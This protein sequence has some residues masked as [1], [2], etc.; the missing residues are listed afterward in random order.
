MPLRLSCAPM[1]PSG[2]LCGLPAS[3]DQATR[4][5]D[6]LPAAHDRRDLS[7]SPAAWPT[8]F[9][10]V[11][12]RPTFGE[13]APIGRP[14][15]RVSGCRGRVTRHDASGAADRRPS[16]ASPPQCVAV[17]PG[18]PIWLSAALTKALSSPAPP[19]LQTFPPA[20]GCTCQES[21]AVPRSPPRST[22][23]P[24]RF[25]ERRSGQPAPQ[26]GK[27]QRRTCSTRA[28]GNGSDG[29]PSPACSDA[30]PIASGCSRPARRTPSPIWCSLRHRYP[31]RLTD[32]DGSQRAS[33]DHGSRCLER[34]H[35]ETRAHPQPLME[36]T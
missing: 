3:A 14:W 30:L 31:E 6:W 4:R 10:G 12:G 29:C 33:N 26:N 20:S 8:A 1:L 15:S 16:C 17:I 18:P 24:V 36:L 22:A 25:W 11:P 9:P 13:S 35:E 5:L 27:H 2:Q 7:N 21:G 34:F 19:R 28:A 23:R 32:F